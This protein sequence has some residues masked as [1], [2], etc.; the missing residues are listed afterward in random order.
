L[1]RREMG[2]F[3]PDA[4]LSRSKSREEWDGAGEGKAFRCVVDSV[5]DLVE[6]AETEVEDN[7]CAA[8]AGVDADVE[9][10]G[11]VERGIIPVERPWVCKAVTTASHPFSRVLI[12]SRSS[13]FSLCCFNRSSSSVFLLVMIT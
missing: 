12:L 8:G 1:P 4:R 9:E 6:V 11:D 7:G 10:A 2:V 13:S 3:G 5:V